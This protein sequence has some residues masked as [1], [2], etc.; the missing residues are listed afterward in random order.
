MSGA[1]PM[2]RRRQVPSRDFTYAFLLR[3]LCPQSVG[4]TIEPSAQK[5]VAARVRL[6]ALQ[7]SCLG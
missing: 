1:K 6:V 7:I 3:A 4:L 2:R 5:V